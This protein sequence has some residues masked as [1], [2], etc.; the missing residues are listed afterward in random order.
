LDVVVPIEAEI[1][2]IYEMDP[3][4]VYELR[5]LLIDGA[6]DYKNEMDHEIR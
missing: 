3:L 2:N 1:F 6:I 4:G 5:E